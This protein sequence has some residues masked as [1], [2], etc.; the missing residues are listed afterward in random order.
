MMI[1]NFNGLDFLVQHETD[2]DEVYCVSINHEGVEMIDMF[3]DETIAA[4]DE[5]LIDKLIDNGKVAQME[6][7]L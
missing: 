5:L 1:I 4:I 7:Q 3:N 6:S 2:N